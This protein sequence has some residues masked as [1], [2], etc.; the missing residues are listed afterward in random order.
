MHAILLQRYSQIK[1]LKLNDY[2]VRIINS[3]MGTQSK[4]LVLIEFL[5][6]DNAN[7]FITVGVSENIIDASFIALNDAI[8][9]FLDFSR[10]A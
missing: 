4:T 1:N 5:N 3:G 10:K 7:T 2:K 8:V 9:Y 6:S